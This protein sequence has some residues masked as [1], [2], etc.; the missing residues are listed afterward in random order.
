MKLAPLLVLAIA[1]P[2]CVVEGQIT[3]ASLSALSISTNARYFRLLFRERIRSPRMHIPAYNAHKPQSSPHQSS[4]LDNPCPH[5]PKTD[6]HSPMSHQHSASRGFHPDRV[7]GRRYCAGGQRLGRQDAAPIAPLRRRDAGPRLGRDGGLRL[8]WRRL[9]V[10]IRMD[11]QSNGCHGRRV[12]VT[13]V[14]D[15]E[16]F[17]LRG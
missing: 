16:G 5:S 3:Y 12:S 4:P 14:V 17:A 8:F 13:L 11:C 9:A 1:I 6:S 10:L 15:L 7:S 2:T